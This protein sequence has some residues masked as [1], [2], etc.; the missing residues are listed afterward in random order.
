MTFYGDVSPA[1]AGALKGIGTA[2]TVF[3][4]LQGL[5]ADIGTREEVLA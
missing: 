3:H 2:F 4:F 5:A 1:L